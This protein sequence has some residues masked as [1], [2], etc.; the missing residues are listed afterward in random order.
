METSRSTVAIIFIIA[1]AILMIVQIIVQ[2]IHQF[3]V[4]MIAQIMAQILIIAFHVIIILA[5]AS[6]VLAVTCYWLW[7]NQ[8]KIQDDEE[9]GCP[10]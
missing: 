1:A 7:Q 5:C 10:H 6:A 8:Q 3:I 4:Q 2:Y 9:P